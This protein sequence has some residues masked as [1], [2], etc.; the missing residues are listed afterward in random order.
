[1]RELPVL[2]ARWAGGESLRQSRSLAENEAK[3]STAEDAQNRTDD[4]RTAENDSRARN[5]RR[6]VGAATYQASDCI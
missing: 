5:S 1:M 2:A 3:L 6:R 4:R